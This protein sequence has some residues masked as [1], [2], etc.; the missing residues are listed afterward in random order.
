MLG[1]PNV[2][3]EIVAGPDHTFRPLW[4]HDVL[5]DLLEEHLRSCA[6]VLAPSTDA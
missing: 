5:F 2:R 1:D 6:D 4:A 3:L